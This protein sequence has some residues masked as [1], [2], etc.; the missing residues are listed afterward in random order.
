M[1]VEFTT[2]EL[3]EKYDA[4]AR[5][6]DLVDAPQERLVV[7]RLRRRLLR[8]ASGEVLEVAV[9]TGANLPHYPEGCRITAVDVSPAMLEI[10]EKRAQKLGLE[11]TLRLMDAEDLGFSD[12]SFDT[13]VSSLTV[14]TLPNP[15]ATLEE[16]ARVCKPNGRILL[17]EHGRSD[18]AWLGRL[19]DLRE[20]SH[21]R[22]LGCHWNR[23]PRELLERAGLVPICAQ[24][25]F[26]GV[27]HEIEAKKRTEEQKDRRANRVEE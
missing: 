24:R 25:T 1:P 13:V 11:V 3:K 18:R 4:F 22:R 23:E 26:L 16:M 21:A 19:Q 10:A 20:D 15:V 27:F 17:L 12:A 7:K 5:W 6:Y 8:R 2:E 14:C 9:G